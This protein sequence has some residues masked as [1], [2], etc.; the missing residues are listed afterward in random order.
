[1]FMTTNSKLDDKL[2]SIEQYLN[3]PV[4]NNNYKKIDSER[5]CNFS[6]KQKYRKKYY[7]YSNLYTSLNYFNKFI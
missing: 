4:Y 5:L 6:N 7:V 2:Y 3:Y 1:M